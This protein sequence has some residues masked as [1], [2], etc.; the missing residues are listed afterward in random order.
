MLNKISIVL[1]CA[2]TAVAAKAQDLRQEVTVDHEVVPE[3]TDVSRLGYTPVVDLPRLSAPRLDYSARTVNVTVP[4]AI[5]QLSPAAYADTLYTTP[6]R[7]YVA[8]GFFPLYNAGASAGYKFLDTDH[9]R[10]SAFMQY[11]GS[12]YHGRYPN[13]TG[14]RRWV[15]NNTLTLDLALHQAVGSKSFIDAG[16]DMAIA[17]YNMPNGTNL[18]PQ[19]MTRIGVQAN[20]SSTAGPVDYTAGVRYHHFSYSNTVL[21]ERPDRN[22]YKPVNENIFGVSGK[23]RMKF[24][25]YSAIG[26][27]AD[28]SVVA[29]TRRTDALFSFITRDYQFSLYDNGGDYTHA[30]ITLKPFYRFEI[31]K[32]RLDLGARIDFTIHSGKA[33]HAAP[34]IRATWKPTSMLA[35]YA[36]AGGG[37]H[38]NT[39]RSL[40]GVTPYA[41]TMMAYTNSHIP[42]T[43]EG[44]IT[45]GSWKGAWL[46]AAVCY[47]RAN[48]W[49]MP[50][51]DASAITVFK[52][53][54][55]R[56]YHWRVAAGYTYRRL[57]ELTVSCEGAPQGY[58]KGYYLW[59]DR[60]RVV[61]GGQLKV[62]PIKPLD[63][64]LTYELR[65]NRTMIDHVGSPAPDVKPYRVSYSLGAVNNL[66]IGGNY[67]FTD[68]LSAFATFSN[69]LC[70]RHSLPGLVE[71]QTFHG[72][73]GVSYKF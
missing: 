66:S 20:F 18:G 10:L 23:A 40:Y 50:V 51:T 8:A 12:L 48:D 13:T 22:L 55:M 6:W 34:D 57:A 60:A 54:D 38:Q 58:D 44:G 19:N 25:Q 61:L 7:G 17:H 14:S 53:I 28:L 26:L 42:L 72:L 39:L 9:T 36:K 11:N 29:N 37:E 35:L 70:Q 30:L 63:L 71:N 5:E 65:T 41:Q 3:R 47:A 4:P 15:R 2:A 43:L 31:N 1:L 52:P 59:R 56:G 32:F 69:I 62:T 68:R 45:L 16:A 33:F 27:D 24:D 64:L 46:E 49:L 73:L 67:R 21:T